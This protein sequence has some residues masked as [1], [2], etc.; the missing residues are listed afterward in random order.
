[1]TSASERPIS[2]RVRRRSG[3]GPG[4]VA[5]HSAGPL[6]GAFDWHARESVAPSVASKQAVLG[7]MSGT[8]NQRPRLDESKIAREAERA[9]RTVERAH[10]LHRR[11]ARPEQQPGAPERRRAGKT[12]R[13]LGPAPS[14]RQPLVEIRGLSLRRRA[15]RLL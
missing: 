10:R 15:P 4:A 6:A 7:V 5:V 14:G 9:R 13:H 12:V 8:A 3:A 1:M 2:K 11:A